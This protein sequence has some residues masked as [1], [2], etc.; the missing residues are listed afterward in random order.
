MSQL[1]AV[2]WQYRISVK[3]PIRLHTCPVV[4]MPQAEAKGH[5]LREA[6]SD[7]ASLQRV[8]VN[9]VDA[10]SLGIEL[11]EE[12]V[13]IVDVRRTRHGR[14][15]VGGGEGA[16]ICS[17]LEIRRSRGTGGRPQLHDAGHRICAVNGALRTTHDFEALDV[18]HRQHAEIKVT[19]WIVHRDAIDQRLVVAGFAAANEQAGLAAA[20]PGGIN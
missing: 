7:I 5:S 9:V 6:H 17:K 10:L 3:P 14:V 13:V 2:G 11:V 19:T 8:R 1:A 16:T 20:P 18:I 4:R 15:S 12:E